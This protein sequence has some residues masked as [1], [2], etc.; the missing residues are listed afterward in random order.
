MLVNCM[1]LFITEH[2][3]GSVHHALT[4]LAVVSQN[5]ELA[6][7]VLNSSIHRHILTLVRKD[8]EQYASVAAQLLPALLHIHIHIHHGTPAFIESGA[9]HI[10]SSGEY[11]SANVLVEPA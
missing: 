1:Q 4:A 6:E 5:S 7:Q 11:N 8:P 3:K 2:D 9:T 10:L